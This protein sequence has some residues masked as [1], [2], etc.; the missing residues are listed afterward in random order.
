M[1]ILKLVPYLLLL[2][3]LL[4]SAGVTGGASSCSSV[5]MRFQRQQD[6]GVASFVTDEGVASGA[7]H[8]FRQ[9]QPIPPIVMYISYVDQLT[10][11]TALLQESTQVVTVRSTPA[12]QMSGNTIAVSSG[13]ALFPSI[14]PQGALNESIFYDFTFSVSGYDAAP[15]TA[16][17]SAGRIP[18]GSTLNFANDGFLYR[19]G[20]ARTVPVGA[21]S[22]PRFSLVLAT[23]LGATE[24]ATSSF[25]IIANCTSGTVQ[26]IAIPSGSA[27]NYNDFRFIPRN[28]SVTQTV[29]SF[30]ARSSTAVTAAVSTGPLTLVQTA[31]RSQFML[32]DGA[33]SSYIASENSGGSAVLGIAIRRIRL[34]FFTSAMQVDTSCSGLVVTA[35]SKEGPLK[36][37]AAASDQGV[38]TFDNLMFSGTSAPAMAVITFT[39]GLR[40][41]VPLSGSVLFSGPIYVSAAPIVASLMAFADS[42]VI[43]ASNPISIPISSSNSF[44]IPTISV[45]MR[46]SA[47][48]LDPTVS[49]LTLQLSLSACTG[50]TDAFFTSGSSATMQSGQAT[51]TNIQ[52]SNGRAGAVSVCVADPAGVR[53]KLCS[54]CTTPI[55][56][57]AP[58]VDPKASLLLCASSPVG[59]LYT[60]SFGAA[61]LSL[62]TKTG[63]PLYATV[64]VQL[65]Q[66]IVILN[67][68]FGPTSQLAEEWV[69]QLV[70]YTGPS[71]AASEGNLMTIHGANRGVYRNGQY[72]FTCLNFVRVPQGSVTIKFAAVSSD[73]TMRAL[74]GYTVLETGFVSVEA[75]TIKAYHLK[76]AT[77][78]SL[79]NW[80]GQAT[81]AVVNTALP[82]ILVQVVDSAGLLDTDAQDIVITCTASSGALARDGSTEAVING[83]ATFSL[84]MFT[85]LAQAPV[86]IFR[87]QRSRAPVSGKSISSGI[88]TVTYKP[89]NAYEIAFA[90]STSFNNNVT[91]NFQP[92]LFPTMQDLLVMSSI[93]LRNSAHEVEP[94][95]SAFVSLVQL[96]TEGTLTTSATIDIVQ[97][98]S[99]ASANFSAQASG[100]QPLY[101]NAPIYLRYVVKDSS[102]P[103]LVG[104]VLTVGPIVISNSP[105]TQTC[106]AQLN[107][108]I[109]TLRL[110]QPVDLITANLPLVQAQIAAQMSLAPAQVLLS[111]PRAEQGLSVLTMAPRTG[112]R[113]DVQFQPFGTYSSAQLAA[114]LV[115]FRA[116]CSSTQAPQ[117]SSPAQSSGVFRS[118]TITSAF[119]KSQELS[120][121]VDGFWKGL[122]LARNCSI[123]QLHSKCQCYAI[124]LLDTY[125]PLC[126]TNV[127]V[128]SEYSSFCTELDF[129]KEID[130]VVSCKPFLVVSSIFKS[131]YLAILAVLAIPVIVGLLVLRRN[132]MKKVLLNSEHKKRQEESD[133]VSALLR[134]GEK[135]TA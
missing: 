71:P 84:L 64:G 52:C 12:V 43:G 4:L 34:V 85:S 100:F 54:S 6:P 8:F 35:S 70:A 59:C 88:I 90:S 80:E 121:D 81:S 97:G 39:A 18:S 83:V 60:L 20:M 116:P 106:T 126:A 61:P 104:Q 58:I 36:G 89:L 68:V 130:V 31:S 122:S 17:F 109:V 72:L 86:L 123:A 29:C 98:S 46:D 128:K 134:R 119:Y 108:P 40:S 21:V 131:V 11:A 75:S 32:F 41:D 3:L 78:G 118:A 24:A 16:R 2:L 66:V 38:V 26:G 95:A 133:L 103:N 7:I 76:F 25:A 113:L 91:Y 62:V 115:Q 74:S 69:P 79:L 102:G 49:D 42:S 65:A 99:R 27:F 55:T 23:A 30:F 50:S 110:E 124:Y 101:R 67:D 37:Y 33:D 10:G 1:S 129:C 132:R 77:V 51:F 127:D 93:V 56:L 28:T 105:D 48:Q 63:Q 47:F 94:T 73:G 135:K 45:Q 112:S 57:R 87:A 53:P 111:N 92:F 13:V 14:T 22:W 19:Q 114:Q 125:G 9:L 117:T 5:L 120:C 15:L 44:S 96:S 82:P 107:A